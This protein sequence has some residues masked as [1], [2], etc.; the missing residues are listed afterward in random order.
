M[1]NN[2]ISLG[3]TQCEFV[4]IGIVVKDLDRT[5]RVLTD[6]FNIGPFHYITYPPEDRPDIQ[7]DYRGAVGNFSHKLAFAR[8]GSV[9]LEIIQPLFGE[10][11]LTEFLDEHGEGI[12]HIRLNTPDLDTSLDFL[13]QK[14]IHPIM[15]GSGLRPGTRWVHLDTA[16]QVGFII[17]MMNVLPNTDGR[18]PIIEN[19]KIKE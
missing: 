3:D 10:S 13:S 14:G 6:I 4:Q 12:H 2:T 17:E 16:D 19:G 5:V 9:E 15:S 11:I 7:L 18:T 1:P 8:L